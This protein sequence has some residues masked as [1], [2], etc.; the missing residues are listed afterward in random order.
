MFELVLKSKL[1]NVLKTKENKTS[2][3]IEPEE[4]ISLA[5]NTQY[6]IIW[7]YYL[8]RRGYSEIIYKEIILTLVTSNRG[9]K[10][11][12]YSFLYRGLSGLKAKCT[13]SSK[14]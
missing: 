6:N 1:I 10:N 13:N 5:W 14:R 7:L 9:I 11:T 4:W 8:S 12:N 2:T 3:D